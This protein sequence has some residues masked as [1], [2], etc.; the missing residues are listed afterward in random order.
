MGLWNCTALS[1]VL[2]SCHLYSYYCDNGYS[3][4]IISST[5]KRK[6]GTTLIRAQG[7]LHYQW[8]K[9][10]DNP[11][12]IKACTFTYHFNAGLLKVQLRQQ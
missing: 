2:Q 4:L 12:R 10:I 11:R 3:I 6:V 1:N 9:A 5:R 7:I 8:K